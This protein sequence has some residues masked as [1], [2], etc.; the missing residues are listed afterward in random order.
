MILKPEWFVKL[1]SVFSLKHIRYAS[2]VG[3]SEKAF[4][5]F[6]VGEHNSEKFLEVTDEL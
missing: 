4:N 3:P 6:T 1:R 2:L 5:N